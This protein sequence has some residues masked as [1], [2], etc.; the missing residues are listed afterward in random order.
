VTASGRRLALVRAVTNL[1]DNADRHGGGV[2]GLRLR[3]TD[4]AAVIDVDDAGPGVPVEE[5][6]R[7]FARFATG[8]GARGSSAGTGLGLALVAETV[9][10]HGG[11]VVCCGGPTGGARFTVTLPREEAR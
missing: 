7:V 3:A 4:R 6:E 9:A 8:R 1:L 11:S 2:V 5:R 10:A